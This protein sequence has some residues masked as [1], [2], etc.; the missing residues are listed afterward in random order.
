MILL[1][2]GN[3]PELSSYVGRNGSVCVLEGVQFPFSPETLKTTWYSHLSDT[4][5]TSFGDTSRTSVGHGIERNGS[6][7]VLEG[8]QFPFS[9]ETLKTTW[10]SHLSDT[11]FTS[12]RADHL[13]IVLSVLSL[14]E[15]GCNNNMMPLK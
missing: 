13:Q 4:L 7:C 9:P 14:A 2:V 3:F 8:V 5:F 1:V 10:Y 11:L 15:G 12:L 6:V